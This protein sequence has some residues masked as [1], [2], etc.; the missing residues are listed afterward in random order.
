M[1]T[2]AIFINDNSND[3]YNQKTQV[4]TQNERLDIHYKIYDKIFFIICSKL[5]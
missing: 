4:S 3:K 1:I 5:Y 2:I